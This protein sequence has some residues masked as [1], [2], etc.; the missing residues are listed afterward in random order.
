MPDNTLNI[1]FIRDY[2]LL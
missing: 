1:S 2:T